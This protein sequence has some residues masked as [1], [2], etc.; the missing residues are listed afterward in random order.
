[1]ILAGALA[2]AHSTG[3]SAQAYPSRPIRVLVPFTAGGSSDFTARTVSERL[4]PALGGTVVVENK[5]GGNTVIATE[6][7]AKSAPDGYTL[8]AGG[9]TTLASQPHLYKKLPYDV[10]KDLTPVNNAVVSPLVLSVHP[11]MPVKNLQELL[12]YMKANPGKVNYGSA[13]VGN[14]LHLAGELLTNMTGVKITHVPYKGAS[15]AITDLLSGNIQMMFD[16]VQTPLQH[17]RAG[18]LRPIATTWDKRAGVLP[19][20]PTMVEAG[21]PGYVFGAMIGFYAPAGVPR[22]ILVRLSAEITKIMAMP[23]VKEAFAKQA[24]DPAPFP[25]PEAHAT[26]FRRE[27]DNMG[28]IIRDAGIQPE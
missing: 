8:L 12:A 20:V 26:A 4:G 21:L 22:D 10:V 1:M 14:T 15:Q 28:K 13:G 19:E 6:L 23:E 9:A 5:P 11:S 16:V 27:I 18:K 7:V 3:A 25:S 17:I 2:A 24:M